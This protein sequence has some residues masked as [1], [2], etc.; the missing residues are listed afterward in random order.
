M[1]PAAG[2]GAWCFLAVYWF[3]LRRPDHP[4]DA[5]GCECT[6]DDYLKVQSA[7]VTKCFMDN[8]CVVNS[9]DGSTVHVDLSPRGV[10][11][12]KDCM[13]KCLASDL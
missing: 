10:R 7:L 9:T 6:N 3:Y 2:A 1:L 13:F 12:D 8:S 5:F 11:V 4:C